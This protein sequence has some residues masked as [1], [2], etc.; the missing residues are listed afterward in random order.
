MHLNRKIYCAVIV[1]ALLSACASAGF[2]PIGSKGS[3]ARFT[4]IGSNGSSALSPL[5]PGS[6]VYIYSSEKEVAAPFR[7]IGNISYRN[8]GMYETLLFADAVP[9]LQDLARKAGANGIIIDELVVSESGG[10]SSM[11]AVSTFRSPFHAEARAIV[12]EQ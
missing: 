7:V 10:I 2:T 1:A 4:P 3:N 9:D 6:P 12:V 5:P 11:G 8:P